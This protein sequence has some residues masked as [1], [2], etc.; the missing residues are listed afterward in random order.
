MP[1]KKL[2]FVYGTLKRGCAN[3]QFLTGQKFLGEART[4]PGFRL[5]N[6]GGYP[7]LVAL[8]DDHDGVTG[9]VWS[10][11]APA[12]V[13]LDALEG[14]GEGHY[15]RESIPLLAPFAEQGIEGYIYNLSIKGRRVIGNTWRE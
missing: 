2:L 11:D 3:H 4:V 10:V 14:L 1:S 8:A 5:Y 9:E 13:R 6:L 7:G 12:L 15:R